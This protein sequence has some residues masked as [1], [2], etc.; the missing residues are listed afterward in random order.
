MTLEETLVD[1]K[2]GELATKTFSFIGV[3]LLVFVL[4]LVFVKN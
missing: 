1:E 3:L 4:F 2:S